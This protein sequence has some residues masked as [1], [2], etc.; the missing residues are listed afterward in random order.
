MKYSTLLLLLL[1]CLGTYNTQAQSI[2]NRLIGLEKDIQTIMKDYHAAGVAIAIVENG[3]IIYSQGFGYRDFQKKLPVDGNTLFGIGSC[4]KAFTASLIGILE[5]QGKLNLNDRPQQYIPELQF[6]NKKMDESVQIRHL[7]SHSLG[8]PNMTTESSMI[9]FPPKKN[10]DLIPRFKYL[11]PTAEVGEE[12]MYSNYSVTAAAVLAERIT[13]EDWKKSLFKLV[14]K[15]IEMNRTTIGFHQASRFSNYSLGY[16]VHKEQIK[17]VMPDTIKGRGPARNIFSSVND[18]TKWM[19][20]WLNNG[21]YKANQ[22][23]PAQFTKLAMSSQQAVPPPSN[24]DE[25]MMSAGFGWFV[26]K[27]HGYEKIHH[28]GGISGYTA[29]VVLF[30]SKQLGIVVLSNQSNSSV[31]FAITDEIENRLL[32]IQQKKEREVRYGGAVI[33]EQPSASMTINQDQPP[34]HELSELVGHFLKEG[35]GIFSVKMQ[36][37]HLYVKFPFTTFRLVHR[38]GNVFDSDFAEEVPTIMTSPFLNFTFQEDG[39]GKLRGVSVNMDADGVLFE[40]VR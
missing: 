3:N 6:F 33:V 34:T 38:Q 4:S 27:Y 19:N 26:E 36:K 8:I 2:D 28:S 18:L 32:N 13:K 29:N 16:A 30:P 7:M 5:G 10:E 14:F 15:P 1:T 22:V 39:N 31:S 17:K 25:I 12:F 11:E 21:K 9:L 20:T 24:S 37:G 40:K 35:Y 23:I